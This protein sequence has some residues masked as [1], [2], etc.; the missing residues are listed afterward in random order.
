[1]VS[2]SSAICAEH[3][4]LTQSCNSAWSFVRH[5]AGHRWIKTGS[6]SSVLIG[7]KRVS[8]QKRRASQVQSLNQSSMHVSSRMEGQQKIR[9]HCDQHKARASIGPAC[10]TNQGQLWC[11]AGRLDHHCHT[12]LHMHATHV[13]CRRTPCDLRGQVSGTSKPCH[14]CP[15]TWSSRGCGRDY[16]IS[17]CDRLLPVSS[18][19]LQAWQWWA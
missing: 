16:P 14:Y 11:R 13:G 2:L 17:N 15:E 10:A 18:S 12:T 19:P 3:T 4:R 6:I 7:N 9:S 8:L 1:M 5:V